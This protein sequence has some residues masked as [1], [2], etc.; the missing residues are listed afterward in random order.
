MER[1]RSRH[2]SRDYREASGVMRGVLVRAVNEG[3]EDELR[4]IRCPVELVWGEIDAEAPLEVARQAAAMLRD[5]RVTV[6][7][8]ADHF[9][10]LSSPE[11]R[12]AVERHLP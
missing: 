2:G 11:L 12:A 6:V 4:S 7:P 9:T 10:P 8:G 1:A 5:A 3:Y